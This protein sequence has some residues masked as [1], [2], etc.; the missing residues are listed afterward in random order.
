MD[1]TITMQSGQLVGAEFE[2]AT[3]KYYRPVVG[4]MSTMRR[5]IAF[6]QSE[7]GVTTEYETNDLNQYTKVGGV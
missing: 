3:P 5:A 2:S 7:N 1:L 6:A 4:C